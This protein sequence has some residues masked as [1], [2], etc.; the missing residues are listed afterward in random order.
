MNR[1]V[2]LP[3]GMCGIGVGEVANGADQIC[4]GV[5]KKQQIDINILDPDRGPPTVCENEP[6]PRK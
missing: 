1:E 6:K 5:R 3:C 2:P 4:S